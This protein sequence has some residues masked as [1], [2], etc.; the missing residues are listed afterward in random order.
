MS[1]FVAH[2]AHPPESCPVVL[3]RGHSAPRPCLGGQCRSLRVAIQAEALIDDEHR[4][5]FVLE[6]ADREAVERFL[7]FLLPFGDL[8]VLPASTAEEAVRRHGCKPA[9]VHRTAG[10]HI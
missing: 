9:T 2:H 6:A 7:A 10:V 5:L 8:Q 4:I 1:L 3:R